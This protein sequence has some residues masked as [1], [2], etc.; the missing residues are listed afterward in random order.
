VSPGAAPPRRKVS[1]GEASARA[2]LAGLRV[3]DFGHVWAGPY[4]SALLGDMGAEVIK[5]ESRKRVDI[6]RRQ[7]PYR[8]GKPGVDRSGVW[9]A[10]NRGKKSV[11]LNLGTEEGRELARE[12][13]E[14][15]DVVIEN[16]APGV[17]AR[18]GLGYDALAARNPGIV[19]ASLSAFGQEGPQKSYVGYGPSLDAWSGLDWMTAYEG[20]APNA[21][22]GM[23]PDTCSGLHGAAAILAALE[24]R[25]S[26][27]KGCY[28]DLSE[29]EVSA[30]L[31]GD[32]VTEGVNGGDVV[33]RGNS[34]PAIF[35]H[36][37]YACAGDDQWIALSTPDAASWAGLCRAIGRPEWAGRADMQTAAARRAHKAEIDDAI[38]AWA[39]KIEAADAMA[40]LQSLGVACGAAHDAAGVFADKQLVA[41]NFFQEVRHPEAGSQNVYGPIWR[42]SRFDVQR[43]QPAPALGAHTDD[44]L[45]NL[46]GRTPGQV[47]QLAADEIAY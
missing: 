34:H 33:L 14:A 28:I 31:I 36:G 11:T 30:L 20:G 37:C 18:L 10:Q 7:G 42:H 44:V 40:Q 26:S 19:M 6:H 5:V 29:L 32:A 25:R 27:G 4:C 21:L 8:G 2:P 43:L 45:V 22:G 9:N 17:M 35:P 38:A 13:A 3:L 24:S 16:F 39:R 12:L 47:A 23:F 46:L 15:C 41:R 1:G